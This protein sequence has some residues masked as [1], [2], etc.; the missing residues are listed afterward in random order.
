M[1]SLICITLFAAC[2]FAQAPSVKAGS[3]TV[4]N[5]VKTNVLKSADKMPDENFSFK[6]SPDVRSYGEVLGHIADAQYLFCSAALGEKNPDKK[7]E[8]TAKSKA[9][10]KAALTEAFAYCDKAYAG[11]TDE[12]MTKAIKL[13]GRDSTMINALDFNSAHTF[14][15]YGNLATYM[16]MKGI[17]PPSSEPRK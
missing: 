9:E 17:I 3:Q 7:V 15:H 12:S 10:L 16:R 5:L 6:P 8:A 4:F 13:F 2:A 1:K 14:E 11:A